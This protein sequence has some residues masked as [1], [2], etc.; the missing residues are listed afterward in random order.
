MQVILYEF[1]KRT[2]STLQPSSTTTKVTKSCVLKDD[3]S[4]VNPVLKFNMG[5][6]DSPADYNYAYIAEYSRYYY[7]T[8][9]VFSERQWIAYLSTDVLASFKSAIG[10]SNL[11][12]LRSASEADHYIKDTMYPV[13]LN[14]SHS[15]KVSDGTVSDTTLEASVTNYFSKNLTD[16]YFVLG[17]VGN[18]NTGVTYYGMT[19]N[20]FS[21]LMNA[22]VSYEPEDMGDVSSG[23]AKQL[24]NPIQFITSCFWF[25]STP[26]G[27]EGTRTI[28]FGYYPVEV[29]NCT[30]INNSSAG[31]KTIHRFTDFIGLS[32]HP[33]TDSS[34][35]N[36]AYLNTLPYTERILIFNPFGAFNIDTSRLSA[37]ASSSGLVLEWYVDYT[38]G[39]ADLY[40]CDSEMH[41]LL[42]STSAQFGVPIKV[43]QLTTN[44]IQM[45][46]DTTAPVVD[47][48]KAALLAASILAVPASAGAVTTLGTAGMVDAGI[49]GAAMV[50]T[51]VGNIE[52]RIAMSI[53]R[54]PTVTSLGSNGSLLPFNS[55]APSVYTTFYDVAEM[56]NTH[57]GRPLCKTKKISTLS[58]FIQ[59]KAGDVAI[60]GYIKENEAITSFLVG[61]FYYE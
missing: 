51:V 5:I 46:K 29:P 3:C 13:T 44:M 10:N 27:L 49:A 18:N 8:N 30:I 1:Q 48:L 22:L 42:V 60:S 54:N 9:W 58:G 31:G 50:G 24:A 25:P 55:K 26:G 35:A 16:G 59:C 38:T 39:M 19:Y 61:G 47:G 17:V 6:S 34:G 23:V 12:V 43:A 56:D 28:Y 53:D 36:Y 2:N 57:D 33:K 7:I 21:T 40:V 11:Y 45:L 32:K 52:S 37:G 20:G 41:Y 4:I 14:T 15:I